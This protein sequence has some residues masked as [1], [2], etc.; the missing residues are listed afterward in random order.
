[1]EVDLVDLAEAEPEIAVADARADDADG[2]E[3]VQ[4][5]E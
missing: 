3:D 5:D 2:N 4:A 1:V